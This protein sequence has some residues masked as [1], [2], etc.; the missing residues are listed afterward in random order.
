MTRAADLGR[1]LARLRGLWP[2]R[3]GALQLLFYATAAAGAAMGLA[4]PTPAERW[5]CLVLS[6][7]LAAATAVAGLWARRVRALELAN[8]QL[9]ACKERD[10]LRWNELQPAMQVGR[11]DWLPDGDRWWGD[12]DVY[13]LLGVP[14]GTLPTSTGL[15]DRVVHPDDLDR[16]RHALAQGAR[17]GGVDCQFR[18]TRA[19]GQVRQVRLCARAAGS[20]PTGLR[21]L[22]GVLVDR[23]D[24]QRN[25]DEL[26][27]AR[28]ALDRI[29]QSVSAVDGQGV[30]RLT[31]RAWYDI[32]GVSRRHQGPIAFEHVFPVVTSPERREAFARCSRERVETVVCGHN[33]AAPHSGQWVETRY[34]PFDDPDASWQGIVM[35]SRDV[36]AQRT[37]AAAKDMGGAA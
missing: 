24:Q 22:V 2:D 35:V 30:Y 26:R 14:A 3:A 23:T 21:R 8:S 11:L 33:P 1:P 37:D 19:D 29:D 16:V 4:A 25:D 12:A 28:F 6:A 15:L 13:R 10:A 17:A 31:N 32:T 36:T 7:A 20:G 5:M 34:L 27:V 9:M 18:L